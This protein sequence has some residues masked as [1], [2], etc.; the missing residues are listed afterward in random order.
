MTPTMTPGVKNPYL[1]HQRTRMPT[2]AQELTTTTRGSAT[3]NPDVRLP[4]NNQ[5]DRSKEDNP[6][7]KELQVE[8][9]GGRM[10]QSQWRKGSITGCKRKA[11]VF[12]GPRTYDK[13]VETQGLRACKVCKVK[14]HNS[15][16]EKEIQ[17]ATKA[18]ASKEEIQKISC[19][20]RSIPHRAHSNH[21]PGNKTSKKQQ[22]NQGIQQDIKQFANPFGNRGNGV[23]V[24]AGI[25]GSN[26]FG[27]PATGLPLTGVTTGMESNNLLAPG[28][29]ANSTSNGTSSTVTGVDVT[30]LLFPCGRMVVDEI[31]QDRWKCTPLATELRE[32]LEER[33]GDHAYL[34]RFKACR[35]P[36]AI[37]VLVEYIDSKFQCKRPKLQNLPDSDIFVKKYDEYR[38]FFS[39]GAIAFTFPPER[40]D[41]LPL[42]QYHA[43]EGLTYMHV[44]WTM[45]HPDI[46]LFCVEPGCNGRLVRDRFAFQK[47]R[48]L[49]PIIQQDHHCIWANV[50]KYLCDNCTQRCAAN[51]GRLLSSLPFEVARCYPVKPTYAGA[52]NE[53]DKTFF[54]LSIEVS[55]DL[56]DNILTYANAGVFGRKIWKRVLR[57]Y[58]RRLLDYFSIMKAGGGTAAPYVSLFEFSGKFYAPSAEQLYD[59]YHSAERSSLTPTGVSEFDRH[60]REIIGIGC[61]GLTAIDWTFSVCNNYT[62]KEKG[63]SSCFTMNNDAG[64]IAAAFLVS[65]TKV[66][67]VAHGVRLVSRRGNFKPKVIATDTWPAKLQFWF[68]IFGDIVGMLGIFHFIKRIT[69]TLR[70][71]HPYFFRA[72]CDL[73]DCIYQYN[74][75][76]YGNLIHVLKNGTMSHSAQP[77]SHEEIENLQKTAKWSQR[78]SRFLRKILYPAPTIEHRLKCWV[79]KYKTCTDPITGQ[80]L[81]AGTTKAVNNQ[82]QHTHHIQW[83]KDIDMYVRT[84]PGPRASHG[85]DSFR[86]RNPEPQLESFHAQFANFGNNRMSDDI[87]DD[88]HLRGIAMRNRKIQ[89]DIDVREG[90]TDVGPVP[91]HIADIPLLQDHHLGQYINSLAKAAGCIDEGLPFKHLNILADDTGEEFLSDYFHSQAE[92]NSKA[93]TMPNPAT[94]LCG[95]CELQPNEARAAPVILAPITTIARAA[96][97]EPTLVLPTPGHAEEDKYCCG[98]FEK[99]SWYK[100]QKGRYPPGRVPHDKGCPKKILKKDKADIVAFNGDL[101]APNNT[102]PQAGANENPNDLQ[103]GV[104]I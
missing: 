84:P 102:I 23:P 67:Q 80:F 55:E 104:W 57:D 33:L 68:K 78:Y 54:Q 72:L 81:F 29:S 48:T 92:R 26:N 17:E 97:R 52:S 27:M 76:D 93:E 9:L 70:I 18:K 60:R 85:L 5:I 66:G 25:S 77:M 28:G 14:E 47:N 91:S 4:P 53:K 101:S 38:R 89:H 7:S 20:L 46:Q 59:M 39:P 96:D 88:I 100:I 2:T 51:D 19:N 3:I 50:M 98:K 95:C 21:C 69:D 83:P 79:D 12:R 73:K 13:T 40:R 75:E 45:S 94:D 10:T 49:V 87:G 58:E 37:A 64:Q 61:D 42:P 103:Q 65:S 86:S 43:I 56:E 36:L 90:R 24:L 41:K 71:S 35:A 82:I 32:E 99:Y 34:D 44:D 74:S 30:G 16:I 15:R 22:S 62:L 63:A 6:S 8:N 31:T 1:R 11:T